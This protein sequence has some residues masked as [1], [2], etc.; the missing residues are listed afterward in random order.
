M[1]HN[2]RLLMNS[3]EGRALLEREVQALSARGPRPGR[4]RSPRG[5]SATT[6]REHLSY[7]SLKERYCTPFEPTEAA[8]TTEALR[9]PTEND[10]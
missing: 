2:F 1:E 5:T 4:Q 10:I 7:T 3:D 9:S 8:P 6:E